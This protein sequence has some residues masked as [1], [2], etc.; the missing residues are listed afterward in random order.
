[1]RRVRRVAGRVFSAHA[2][3]RQ[4]KAENFE[5]GGAAELWKAEKLGIWKAAGLAFP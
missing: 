5:V 4:G 1:M 3:F 2:I